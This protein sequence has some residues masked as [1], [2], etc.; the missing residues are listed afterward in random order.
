[1]KAFVAMASLLACA[2][3]LNAQITAVLERVPGH[4]SM[5]AVAP[6]GVP[7]IKIRNISN[8]NL[9]AF[10]ISMAPADADGTPFLFY[11]D[12]AVD[13]RAP[14]QLP[15]VPTQEY[16]VN[17]PIRL[18]GSRQIKDLYKQPIVTAEVFAD[19]TTGG[20]AILLTRLMSR[21][22]SMLQAVELA[23]EIL[24][25]AAKHNVPPPQLIEQQVGRTV[26]QSITQKLMDLPPLEV[27]SPFPPTAFVEKETVVLNRQRST[28][29]NSR[30]NIA[31]MALGRQ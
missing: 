17:V 16:V 23:H 9:T 12:S 19:G 4:S 29:L 21:R 30:P 18:L 7:E 1:M 11:L 8:V 2:F 14:N 3:S 15:L 5:I 26:H 20:D 6:E 27:G 25:N 13:D 10:A 24:A 31:D 22:N 28:L